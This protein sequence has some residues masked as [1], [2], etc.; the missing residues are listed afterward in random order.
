MSYPYTPSIAL[1]LSHPRTKLQVTSLFFRD[2]Y[3]RLNARQ[4]NRPPTHPHPPTQA[5][6][7]E[8]DALYLLDQVTQKVVASLLDRQVG[9]VVVAVLSGI[10][11]SGAN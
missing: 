10:M 3:T 5:P 11:R 8:A 6:R 7:A 4:P 9:V 2:P 1:N